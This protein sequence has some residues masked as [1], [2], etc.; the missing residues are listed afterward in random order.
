MAAIDSQMLP[1]GTEAPDFELADPSGAVV[2]RDDFKGKNGLLVMF[3]CNH[4]PYVKHVRDE[5]A[6]IGR[7]YQA[8]GIG[9]VAINSNDYEQYPEDSPAAMNDEIAAAGYTFPYL[10]DETQEVAR[11]YG[12]VCTPDTFLFDGDFK[13]A[14]RGQLDDTR[15]NQGRAA[16]GVDI[17][18]ALEAVLGDEAPSEDQR[19]STGCSIKWRSN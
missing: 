15:P 3:I 5:L 6:R 11:A 2:R 1:L 4:C 7:D 10:V 9:I 19:A 16:N 18:A 13:L 12:A 14:Y 17:R 8:K